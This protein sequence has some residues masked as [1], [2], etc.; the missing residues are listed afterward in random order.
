MTHQF[1]FVLKRPYERLF[2]VWFVVH[3]HVEYIGVAFPFHQIL[4]GGHILR[5]TR[6][7][8]N[9]PAGPLLLQ[10]V[11]ELLRFELVLRSIVIKFVC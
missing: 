10:I 5:L 2:R 8:L 6:C 1:E 4:Q 11:V 9:S 3:L 7:S